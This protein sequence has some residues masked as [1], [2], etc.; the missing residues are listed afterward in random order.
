MMKKIFVI[1]VLF[2]FTF[3]LVSCSG[4]SL[5]EKMLEKMT[6]IETGIDVDI[7][8]DGENIDISTED[9]DC[10]AGINQNWP[11]SSMGDIPVLKGT[12]IY[13][14]E[15]EGTGSCRIALSEVEK[16]D[17][18]DFLNKLLELGYKGEKF[19]SEAGI[20]FY[21]KN[22]QGDVV[23]F[24]YDSK[25]KESM[26]TFT[27]NQSNATEKLQTQ[28]PIEKSVDKKELEEMIETATE[29]DGD[30][31]NDIEDI[32]IPTEDEDSEDEYYEVSSNLSWPEDSMGD[33]PKL[34]GTIIDV[35]EQEGYCTITLS[36]VE[37]QDSND[38]LNK[39]L[40]LG[41]N[42]ECLSDGEEIIFE[43]QNQQGNEISYTFNKSTKESGI[44]YV[45]NQSTTT[46]YVDMTDIYEWPAEYMGNNPELNGKIEN[47]VVDS[48]S[49]YIFVTY[50]TLE[51]AKA[52]VQDIQ[53]AGYNIDITV[54][55]ITRLETYDYHY[56]AFNIDGNKIRYC[57]NIFD[58]GCEVRID[59]MKD[60]R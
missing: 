50:V 22:Q 45:Y 31:L 38:F 54:G 36:E 11:E 21:A 40:Q 17:A 43:A 59:L 19:T 29:I 48:L 6:G 33:I 53:N 58:R 57:Y 1:L 20:A 32:Q 60:N 13:V 16:Q 37:E 9:K 55:G 44:S 2:I 15:D 3:S 14:E 30:I 8:N 52:Y 56:Q 51:D 47:V 7:S 27:S 24:I 46:E 28:T 34:E 26:I 42:G 49:A 4:K 12:I 35:Y 41:Y 5:E 10:E 23:D 18:K 25:T 39:L